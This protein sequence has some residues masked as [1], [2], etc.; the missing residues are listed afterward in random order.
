MI[1]RRSWAK[2]VELGAR[3][4]IDGTSFPLV[5][6]GPQQLTVMVAR[7]AVTPHGPY[8]IPATRTLTVTRASGDFVLAGFRLRHTFPRPDWH[9]LAPAVET[10]M[11]PP[12]PDGMELE[13]AYTVTAF[14]PADAAGWNEVRA[15]ASSYPF[16]P[17]DDVV[18]ARTA[19]D[20][21]SRHVV[22]LVSP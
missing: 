21:R 2:H 4:G 14:D 15:R 17:P 6:L 19:G 7:A 3:I 18:E 20:Y 11:L 16:M 9:V 5:P 13:E 22:H 10:Q 12:P 8:N 1:E